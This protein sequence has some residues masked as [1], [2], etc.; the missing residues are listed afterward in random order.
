MKYVGKTRYIY[1]NLMQNEGKSIRIIGLCKN[2]AKSIKW[3]MFT[4]LHSEVLVLNKWGLDKWIGRLVKP[5]VIS[6]QQ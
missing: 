6:V 4:T 5:A 2:L 1:I 3:N